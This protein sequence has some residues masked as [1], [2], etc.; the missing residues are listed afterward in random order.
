[1]RDTENYSLMLVEGTDKVNPLTQVNPNFEAIDTQMKENSDYAVQP[2]TE[3]TTGT[4]HALTR[5]QSDASVFR[6]TATSRFTAGDTFTVDGVQ[7]SALTT[8]GEQLPDGAYVIGAE[9]LCNLKGSVLTVYYSMNTVGNAANAQKLN[10]QNANYYGTAEAV[11][12]AQETATSAGTL[13]AQNS[14]AINEINTNI[15]NISTLTVNNIRFSKIGKLVL[16]CSTTWTGA[17]SVVDIP[18]NYQPSTQLGS[19]LIYPC[20]VNSPVKSENDILLVTNNKIQCGRANADYIV[21]CSWF[22]D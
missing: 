2:A 12:Q 19:A 16:C 9:V 20:A 21:N 18:T 13:A 11:A 15:S 6:F 5:L 22:T 4:V 3:L 17:G 8:S 10:G 7:V 14:Q 1:M